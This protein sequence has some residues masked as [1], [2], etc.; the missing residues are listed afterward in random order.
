VNRVAVVTGARRGIGAAI[1][2]ALAHAGIEVLLCARSHADETIR[3][4]ETITAATG[5]RTATFIGDLT[6][7]EEIRRLHETA[8]A[9]FGA[10]DILVNNA[11]GF[12]RSQTTTEAPLDDWQQQLTVNLTVPFQLTQAV[13]PGMLQRGW[14]RIINIGSVV[15]R[16]P[17]LGNAIGY[18]AAKAGLLGF[19][20]QL[21]LEV[22]GTGVTVNVVNPGTIATE[23]LQDHFRTMP[24][25]TEAAIAT[26]IPVGRLGTA[27][28]VA[29]ILPY[30]VSEK[31]AF[32]TGA[33]FD[34]T[35]GAGTH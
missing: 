24:P 2:S 6:D 29:A 7:I 21:A 32:T 5:C 1:A 31:S 20:R 25:G 17:A 23:H 16:A 19:S 13:L 9:E 33:S 10:V 3:L 14:G 8:T 28:E 27:D 30:L 22:A 12:I 34:V 18:V 4:A 35:G 26:T 11:G 15:A